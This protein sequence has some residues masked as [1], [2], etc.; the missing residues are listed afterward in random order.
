M[1]TVKYEKSGG[2]VIIYT[3]LIAALCAISAIACFNMQVMNRDANVKASRLIQKE[4]YVQR[5]REYLL[6]DL[7]GY[8]DLNFYA[9]GSEDIKEFFTNLNGFQMVYGNSTLLYSE[10]NEAFYLCYYI[11][12]KFYREE[13]VK[14]VVT[15]EGI[16]FF[17][18]E[19]SYRKGALLE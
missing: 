5:D 4:D 9:S 7:D 1:Y 2:F 10:A 8:I 14:Y 19:F 18:S 11:E 16:S 17:V 3:V 15:N 13:M 6:T 12:G